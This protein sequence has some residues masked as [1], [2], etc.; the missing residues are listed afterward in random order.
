[1]APFRGE[2]RTDP[3]GAFLLFRSV[4]DARAAL[5]ALDGRKGPG[6]ETLRVTLSPAP[7]MHPNRLWR[8]VSIQEGTEEEAAFFENE[9]DKL[10]FGTGKEEE[11][12]NHRVGREVVD[13]RGRKVWKPRVGMRGGRFGDWMKARWKREKNE[14]ALRSDL[15]GM[16]M[17][18]DRGEQ[19]QEELVEGEGETGEDK[20]VPLSAFLHPTRRHQL[21]SMVRDSSTADREP[22]REG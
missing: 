20:S 6:G 9:C 18:L 14:D 17:D 12:E 3:R 22:E 21:T 5:R 8:W 7:A 4:D 11:E 19:E 1:V 13:E 10:G 15:L 2:E 16:Q